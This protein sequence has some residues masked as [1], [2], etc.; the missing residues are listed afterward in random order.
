MSPINGCNPIKPTYF[1][2][3][4]YVNKIE[5]SD[6]VRYHI[7][8]T[9][10]EFDKY[11]KI[12]TS[13]DEAT[14]LYFLIFS[15]EKE[16]EDSNLIENHIINPKEINEK[17]VFFDSL[18]ISHKRIKDLHQFVTDNKLEYDYRKDEVRVSYIDKKNNQEKIYWY[19]VN[20]E[21]IK[22]FMDDFIKIYKNKSMSAKD[23]N[24]FIKSAIV[25][26]L[27]TRIHPFTDGNGRTSRII[28]DMK[29]TESI[30][31]V[32]GYNLKISPLHLSQSICVNQ[33]TYCKRLNNI[34]FDLEH[35]NNKEINEWLNFIL[36]MYDEQ[37]YC[38]S[39]LLQEKNELLN[40]VSKINKD[41]EIKT[42][43]K[44]MHLKK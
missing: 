37:I 22:Q 25:H 28:Q 9:S 14:I 1:S 24:A 3:E 30:N 42:L 33:P 8:E 27:L 36:N 15:F 43:S 12:L 38:M 44:K 5:L 19:G 26:L 6:N 20:Q 17:N 40:K 7:E 34:Y 29:F 2:L 35:D 21:D 16:M 41:I 4:E 31:K 18:T 39:S 11:I 32:Y 13:F 23:N 10:E